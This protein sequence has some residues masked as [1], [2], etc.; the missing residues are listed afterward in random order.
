M[1]VGDYVVLA[2]SEIHFDTPDQEH[3]KWRRRLESSFD[4]SLWAVRDAK[5]AEGHYP[6]LIYAPSDS[7]IAWENADLCEY[8]VTRTVGLAAHLSGGKIWTAETISYSKNSVITIFQGGELRQH[9][10][11]PALGTGQ[12]ALRTGSQRMDSAVFS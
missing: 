2:D 7:S 9:R 4:I 5:M 6:V 11:K 10:L 12:P 1:T 3:N 8:L